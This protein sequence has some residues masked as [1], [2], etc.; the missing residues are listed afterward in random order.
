M[1]PNLMRVD[2][3]MN[4][5]VNKHKRIRMIESSEAQHGEKRKLAYVDYNTEVKN[6]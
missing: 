4:K 6:P 1:H 5:C 3:S 2:P